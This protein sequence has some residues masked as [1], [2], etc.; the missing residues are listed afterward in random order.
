MKKIISFLTSLSVLS[1]SSTMI[2]S[3]TESYADCFDQNG[4]NV[5][6]K[7]SDQKQWSDLTLMQIKMLTL[8]KSKIPD[9]STFQTMNNKSLVELNEKYFSQIIN[10]WNFNYDFTFL[11]TNYHSIDRDVIGQMQTNKLADKNPGIYLFLNLPT[12]DINN[13]ENEPEINFQFLFMIKETSGKI[14]GNNNNNWFYWV[15][16]NIEKSL[17]NNNDLFFNFNKVKTNEQRVV[18]NPNPTY[19]DYFD[20]NAKNVTD[21]GSDQKQ[22]SDLTL[23]QIKMLTLSKSKIPNAST[24]QTMNNKSLNETISILN[25]AKA[26]LNDTLQIVLPNIIWNYLKKATKAMIKADENHN[27][28]N[29]KFQQFLIP[30]GFG[31]Q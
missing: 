20:E 31:A 26:I 16:L 9:A 14:I 29:I 17:P 24:F 27:G 30:K 21:K 2:I 23:M 5:T 19:E 10:K 15:D 18:T 1:T 3:C 11:I 8:S 28:V 7:G 4:K 12:I 25:N 22:W 6:D 13:I